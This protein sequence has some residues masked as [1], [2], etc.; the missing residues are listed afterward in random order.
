MFYPE[1]IDTSVSGVSLCSWSEDFL[2]WLRTESPAVAVLFE[3][4]QK[5][6][7]AIAMPDGEVA[8]EIK[9]VFGHLRK[10]F[11]SKESKLIIKNV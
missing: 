6:K 9:L 8:N 1:K 11:V 4:A 2:R 5:A 10:L 7:D 3:E